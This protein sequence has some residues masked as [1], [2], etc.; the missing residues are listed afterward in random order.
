[1][2]TETQFEL[3]K[4]AWLPEKGKP[5]AGQLQDL[6]TSLRTHEKNGFHVSQY[7]WKDEGLR[8]EMV[9]NDISKALSE[10]ERQ[11]EKLDIDVGEL[12]ISVRTH[13][14][15]KNAGIKTVRELVQKTKEQLLESQYFGKKGIQ[16]IQETLAAMGLSLGMKLDPSE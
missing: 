16:E 13:N 4:L 7:E 12:T 3:L 14:C 10:A 1:M 2:V 8:I 5:L 9:R 11:K 15:L 6:V